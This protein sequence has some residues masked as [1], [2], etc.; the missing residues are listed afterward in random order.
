MEHFWKWLGERTFI[1]FVVLCML[2]H[3]MGLTKFIVSHF[4]KKRSTQD[5]GDVDEDTRPH[6]RKTDVDGNYYHQR[7]EDDNAK[8]LD[9]LYSKME[10][11]VK[12]DSIDSV[13]LAK[14]DSRVFALETSQE[15]LF[16][17]NK[18]LFEKVDKINEKFDIMGDKIDD[19]F[20]GLAQLILGKK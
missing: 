8:R 17:Q 11:A 10:D 3:I 7:L 13:V 15:H 4:V 12:K 14:I 6:R 19:K 1:E 9:D 2:A 20:D 5:E 18:T 16:N